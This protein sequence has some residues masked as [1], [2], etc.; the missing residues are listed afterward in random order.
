MNKIGRAACFGAIAAAFCAGVAS[1]GMAASSEPELYKLEGDLGVHDPVIIKEGA[2]YYIFNTGGAPGR[3]IIPIRTSTDMHKWKLSGA[4][5]DKLPD[6]VAEEVPKARGAWAPDISFFDGEFHLYYAVS[7]FG[8]NDS[9]IGLATNKTLDPA[10]PNYKWVDQGMVVRST[11]GVDD[12]NAI[13]ANLVV[14]DKNHVW[15]N[16]GSFWGGIKMKRIDPKTGKLSSED[17]TLYSLCSRPRLKPHV[18]PPVE[19]AVEAPFIFL[20]D[21]YWYLFVSYDFCC[22]GAKSDYNVV[23]GRSKKITGP[24]LDKTGKSLAEGAGTP[25]VSAATEN[26]HGAGHEAVFRDGK[27]DFLVFHAY[28]AKNGRSQLQISTMVWENGWP[29]V[30][31]LP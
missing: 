6:W 4:V 20:H 21:G 8:V 19:G 7:S 17:A 14:E 2:T 15:L 18:T 11:G 5:F 30:A 9:A 16:W 23:V 28:D 31:A 10:S 22:R 27:T 3:G 25:V 13:D 26:W 12:F 29:R 1:F 24:Y